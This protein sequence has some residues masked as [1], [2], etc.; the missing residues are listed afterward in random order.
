MTARIGG[1]AYQ[2]IGPTALNYH[3]GLDTN[4]HLHVLTWD[5]ASSRCCFDGTAVTGDSGA[6]A[7]AGNATIGSAGTAN[8]IAVDMF[9]VILINGAV[10]PANLDKL[11]GYLAAK[12][13]LQANLPGAHPYKSAAPLIATTLTAGIV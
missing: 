7:S 8:W 13:G 11:D 3:T 5:G 1:T 10:L 6:T 12:Y 9:E 2:I 4:A